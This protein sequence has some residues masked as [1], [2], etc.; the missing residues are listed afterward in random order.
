M[1]RRENMRKTYRMLRKQD[2]RRLLGIL[3][4]EGIFAVWCAVGS[5]LLYHELPK[6]LFLA[7]LVSD[8]ITAAGLFA[9]AKMAC[10]WL[11]LCTRKEMDQKNQEEMKAFQVKQRTLRHD[12]NI[13]LMA[14]LGMMDAKKFDDCRSYLQKLLD[15]S[16]EV[17]QLMPL[18]DPAVSAML[19]QAR[20]HAKKQGVHVS[21]EIYD[22]LADV[23]C[24]PYELNQILG[25]LIKNAVEAVQSFPEKD[26]EVTVILLKRRNHTIFRVA[27]PI[28]AGT[29]L[30]ES[31]FEYGKSG[32]KG[33]SGIGLAAVRKLVQ[34]YQ[35]TVFLEQEGNRVCMI[36]QI[37]VAM[38]D[39]KKT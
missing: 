12:L 6:N 19:N 30:D 26:R 35:G 25:N 21:Y 16:Q 31:I 4:A 33:H 18:D 23:A 37:P 34:S 36:V 9:V 29:V 11:L 5:C 7:V 8:L 3:T 15:A 32:K 10:S 17:A 20:E 1:Q 14:I 2:K 22:D 38:P 24:N 13:H 28:P 39:E 27:N